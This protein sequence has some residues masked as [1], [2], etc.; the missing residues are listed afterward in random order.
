M[1]VYIW[2]SG[3]LKN[4]YIGEVYEYSY[5]FSNKTQATITADWWTFWNTSN[6]SSN[7]DGISWN[8]IRV[9]YDISQYVPTANKITMS[10]VCSLYNSAAAWLRLIKANGDYTWFTWLF[11]TT[12]SSNYR[13]PSIYWTSWTNVT[14]YSNWVYTNTVELDF[15]SDLQGCTNVLYLSATPM[16]EKYLG[17]IDE[18]KNCLC[19]CETAEGRDAARKAAFYIANTNVNT[20]RTILIGFCVS[21]C[22]ILASRARSLIGS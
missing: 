5:D 12:W 16:L 19:E 9:G 2:T 20:K 8:P 14:P 1:N 18:F 17:M 6:F 22:P 7:S 21:V 3:E 4:A 10:F 13:T 11:V 15:V